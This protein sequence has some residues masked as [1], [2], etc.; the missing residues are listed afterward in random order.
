MFG[1]ECMSLQIITGRAGT[2]K[3]TYLIEQAV[4]SEH[5]V[6]Y[7]VPEQ[8]TFQM[9]NTLLQTANLDGMM[10]I[11]VFSFN[12]LAWKVM[13]ETG[14]L[15]RTFLSKSG[16]EMVLR[17]AILAEQD[18][19]KIFQ[20]AAM[21]R[22]FYGE[23]ASL[24]KE[25]KQSELRT[26]AFA[27]VAPELTT[28]TADKLHDI[29]LLFDRYE[30]MLAGKYME[31][32]DYLRLLTNS[33]SRSTYIKQATVI[34]DGFDSFT[35]QEL[36]V[37]GALMEGSESVRIALS[38]PD[39]TASNRLDAY[40]LFQHGKEYLDRITEMARQTQI[41]ILPRLHLESNKR[42]N[43]PEL[44]ELELL[45]SEESAP[46]RYVGENTSLHIHQAN[47]RRAEAEG[48]A[49]KIRELI[50]SRQF[51]Y[52]DIA[53]LVRGV[54]KYETLVSR[55]FQ[56]N[57]VPYFLDKKRTMAD[58]P[59]IEFIRST[60]EAVQQNW[61]YE[62]IF[63][64]IRTEF[65][66]DLETPNP[67]NRKQADLLE[68]YCIE[69]GIKAKW[70]WQKKGDWIYQKV[71]GLTIELAPQ[72]DEELAMQETINTLRYRIQ[73]PL[74]TLETAFEDAVSG[75][76]YGTALYRY[77]ENVQA[78]ERLEMWREQAEANNLLELARE[79]EQAWTAVMGMLDEFVEILGDDP[80]D[81]DTFLEVVT[82]GLDALEFSLLPPTL[83][84]VI[85][86]DMDV[87]RLLRVKVLFIA[88][89]NDGVLP[90]RKKDGGILSDDDR[91]AIS[92]QGVPI[93]SGLT[94]HLIEEEHLAYRL[95]TTA[96]SQL[97]LSYPA[98]DDE[99][100]LL[101]ESNY[102]RKIKAHFEMLTEEIYLND[103]SLLPIREQSD[104]V[105]AKEATLSQLTAQ[106]Q[107]YKRGYP[108]ASVWWDAYN[109]FIQKSEWNAVVKHVLGS[110][111]Y[112]NRTQPIRSE[113]AANLFGEN[114][115]ASV[116]RMEK[117]FSCE[118]QHFAQYGLKLEERAEFKLQAVDMG[119]VFHGA[120]E[121]I[122]N[123]IKRRQ[124]EWGSLTDLECQEI[125]RDAI[126]YL[127][128]KIQHEILLSTKRMAYIQYKLEQI[129][130]RATHV[131]NRQAKVSAFRPLGLEVDFGIK[132]QLPPMQIKL[133]KQ[134]E[135]LL[136]G[137]VDRIDVAKEEDR[138]FLRII[139]YKSSSHDL[140]LTEVYYG[141]ALQMLTY[142]DIVVQNAQKLIGKQAEPAGVLYFH[143]H[144][145][146]VQTDKE[147]S[148]EA[149][150]EELEKN[151]RMKGLILE[152]P[153]VV[154]LMDNTLEPGKQSTVIPADLK[155]DGTLSARSRT[156]SK[157]EFDAMRR[158]VRGKYQEAGNKMMDGAVSIN[159]YNLQDKTPCQFCAFRS[160]CQFDPSLEN[161]TYRY[162]QNESPEQVIQR[163]KAEEEGE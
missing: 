143:M 28:S 83:D 16:I 29:Q 6:I 144:N 45:F 67:L 101:A 139:D 95:F 27:E 146:P 39:E 87:A 134:R 19:L 81:F 59:F 76:D 158:F 96:S 46:K 106:L 94:S 62:N 49:R 75:I 108:V 18:K 91:V 2:G 30:N 109:Y 44:R 102:L 147:L 115:F 135:L 107:L 79:H 99:G 152:D 20:R 25:I 84:Q 111:F 127:A 11:Q 130:A 92:E 113:T 133:D 103:P 149:I 155:R 82:T 58:H 150:E 68:N 1:G 42:T 22:G 145:Q 119:E 70:R 69:N 90:L 51:D 85:V 34:I 148:E 65:F 129:I 122:S 61:R 13:Q 151:F 63:Q 163:M 55:A 114:I 33:I 56:G 15:A 131:L 35:E 121:W 12:R 153:V 141:L 104:Y 26:E 17:K 23:I 5:P 52:K 161:N 97:Y 89:A 43:D 78:A 7:I 37:I 73:K 8:M 120:M 125:A 93:R 53:V 4:T 137:R 162:L 117:F 80:L 14:G 123:E 132:G 24:F 32:E 98:A 156:A 128:P 157:A 105:R 41:E 3:T 88:G 100:K 36:S 50:A 116:S 9:E 124:Q 38:L 74:E 60:L 31:S 126:R 64:A 66:F 77:L 112:G 142:L 118:F 110:L 71:K 57:E 48:I 86:S 10:N 159:P 21:K 72:T 54:D 154:S 136:Q 138:S 140:R 160:V 40:S 47:N